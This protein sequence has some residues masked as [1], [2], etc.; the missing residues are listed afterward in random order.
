MTDGHDHV[1]VVLTE[2]ADLDPVL[3]T[4]DEKRFMLLFAAARNHTLVDGIRTFRHPGFG[5]IDMFVSPVGPRTASLRYQVIV[6]RLSLPL[7]P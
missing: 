4:G 2:V 5:E 7:A 1:D 3:R 6:N